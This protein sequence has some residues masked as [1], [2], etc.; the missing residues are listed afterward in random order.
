M[1]SRHN[2]RIHKRSVENP[3]LWV[4]W[5]DG[6]SYSKCYGIREISLPDKQTCYGLLYLLGWPYQH[7]QRYMD[8][9]CNEKIVIHHLGDNNAATSLFNNLNTNI[10]SPG[11]HS[12]YNHICQNLNKFCA[13]PWHRWKAT[14]RHQYFST[15]RRTA[16]T[17]TTVILL[18]FTFIQTVC[19]IIQIV[20][21]VW[22]L[23]DKFLSD[24]VQVQ[25]VQWVVSTWAHEAH[26]RWARVADRLLDEYLDYCRFLIFFDCHLL[27][28]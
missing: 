28:I 8:L 27:F 26:A 5:W 25:C 12:N 19:S 15:P 22:L 13:K 10:S 23:L 24:T 3:M 6:N 4:V 14:L 7:Y 21:I 2:I 1:L 17:I 16:S 20:P 9:L 11:V 18:V